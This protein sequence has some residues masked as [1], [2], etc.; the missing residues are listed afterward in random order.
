MIAQPIVENNDGVLVVRDDFIPGGTKRSFTDQLLLGH[1]EVV[2][3]SPVYGG[4]QI[5]IA[6]AAREAGIQSTIFCA[7]RN[8]P[9]PRT[10]EAHRAGAKIVQIPTGYLTNVRAKAKAYC[11]Q[12]GA[13]MLPFGLETETAFSAIA[14]RAK[15]AQEQAG[16]I[17][18]VWCVGG[19]GVLC[20]GLQRGIIA[21]SFHVVQIGRKLKP[22]DIGKAKV[23]IHSLDFAQDAKIKPPFPS[24]SNYDAKA[25]EFVK[26]YATG[27]VL[28]WNVMK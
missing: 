21:K 23:Y 18:Q 2:Y 19:S 16:E 17:D 22:T 15:V 28:F 1:N 14:A 24:C 5:A 3:A 27:R 7:K 4:A 26:R 9:H 8:K 13:H 25:W 12:T 10:V 11:E 6:H 20:R